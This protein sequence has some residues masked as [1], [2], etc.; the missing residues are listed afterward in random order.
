MTHIVLPLMFWLASALQPPVRL[1]G[2]RLEGHADLPGVRLWYRDSGGAGVPVVFMHAATGSSRVWEYQIPAFDGGGVPR[3]R[4][5]P[6]RVR[7]H[8]RSRRAASSRAPRPTI[9]TR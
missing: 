9:F 2:A 1:P 6:A 7:A 5:R 8:R 3:D 4:V